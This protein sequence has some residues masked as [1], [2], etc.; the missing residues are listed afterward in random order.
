MHLQ[1]QSLIHLFV[2]SFFTFVHEIP[3]LPSICSLDKSF[4]LKTFIFDDK[5]RLDSTRSPIHLWKTT[6]YCC[7]QNMSS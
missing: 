5:I 6:K 1:I 7:Y 2:H 4:N 3:S